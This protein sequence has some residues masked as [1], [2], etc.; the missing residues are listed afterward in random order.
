MATEMNTAEPSENTGLLSSARLLVTP[1]WWLAKWLNG[2]S[3]GAAVRRALQSSTDV[4]YATRVHLSGR[5]HQAGHART[6]AHTANVHPASQNDNVLPRR[7]PTRTWAEGKKKKVAA[8]Y[9]R[10][11]HNH[12]NSMDIGQAPTAPHPPQ[13]VQSWKKKYQ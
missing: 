4:F 3:S 5:L 11:A 10:V 7:Q 6:L 1:N 8:K 2:Y 9:S 13:L 12:M